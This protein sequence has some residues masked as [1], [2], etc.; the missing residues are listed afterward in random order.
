MDQASLGFTLKIAT[1]AAE[2]EKLS[3][4]PGSQNYR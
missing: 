3:I 4:K 1:L 2:T